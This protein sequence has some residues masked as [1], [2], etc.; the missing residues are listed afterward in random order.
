[1]GEGIDL[2]IYLPKANFGKCMRQ[3]LEAFFLSTLMGH[4]AQKAKT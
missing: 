1:M 3:E 4:R 2:L